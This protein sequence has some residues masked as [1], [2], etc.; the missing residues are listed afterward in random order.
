MKKLISLIL[1]LLMLL[2]I[3]CLNASAVGVNLS[4]GKDALVAQWQKG[5]EHG[6]DYRFYSP[7]KGA[8]DSTKYPIVI[9]LHGKY[10]GSHEGEQLT[11]TDFFKWSSSEFQS[12]FKDAGG[13][14]I[15]MPRT[16]GG[17]INTWD[18]SSYHGSLK[19][20]IDT[21]VARY[22]NNIDK[23]RI[24]L[25]GWSMGGAGVV[26]MASKYKNFFAA[27]MVIA[28]FDSVSQS[29]MNDLKNTPIWLVTCTQ[30][31][32]ASYVTFAEPFWTKVKD[33]TNVPSYCR[34]TTF[35]K[36]NYYDAGH[37][38]VHYAVANDMQNQ[39]SDCGMSTK[40][41]KGKSISLNDS[42]TMI[43]WLSSQRLGQAKEEVCHCDCHASSLWT[44]FIWAITN[45]FNMI[46]SPGKKY[47][48]CGA[49]H[50]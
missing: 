4:Q 42:S 14:F 16:P 5:N 21:V 38:Y 30:D 46:F 48:A 11:G 9:L 35:K 37:H 26:S 8:D 3:V 13:A 17:D 50:W 15:L 7:V 44:K 24:Y 6:F 10:S 41:A 1:C 28:P 23:S 31:I 40:D 39:P 27:L 12:R 29:Q 22:G 33:T 25:G 32:T 2:P 36:Y 47:C 43:T 34:I 49:S 19:S 18:N 20:L 45:F